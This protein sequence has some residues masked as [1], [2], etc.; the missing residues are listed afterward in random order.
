M[1]HFDT[2]YVLYDIF[3]TVQQ[4]VRELSQCAYKILNINIEAIA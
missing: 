3:F 4:T 2:L 1:S